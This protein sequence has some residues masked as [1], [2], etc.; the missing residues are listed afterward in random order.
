MY[1]IIF[2]DGGEGGRRVG[3]LTD[4]IRQRISKE[5]LVIHRS[6]SRLNVNNEYHSL[7]GYNI[8]F[9][10]SSD[11]IN[12]KLEPVFTLDAKANDVPLVLY[13]GGMR[14]FKLTG[15]NSCEINDSLLLEK[16]TPFLEYLL[17]HNFNKIDF[18]FLFPGEKY[19]RLESLFEL[20]KKIVISYESGAFNEAESST[21]EIYLCFEE[22]RILSAK[23]FDADVLTGFMD[24]YPMIISSIDK[25]ILKYEKNIK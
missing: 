20:R 9:I 13:S 8:A 17:S 1:K 10:H 6:V 19:L 5:A 22:L 4:T 25:N 2:I 14:G 18:N 24:N 15:S 11:N 12:D 21:R 23:S 7:K 16:V 3:K